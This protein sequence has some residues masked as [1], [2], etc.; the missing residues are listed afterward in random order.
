MC[1]SDVLELSQMITDSHISE[2]NHY[3]QDERYRKLTD[4][5]ALCNDLDNPHKFKDLVANNS[6]EKL[7]NVH[8]TFCYKYFDDEDIMYSKINLSDEKMKILTDTYKNVIA[9]KSD[10]LDSMMS[11]MIFSKTYFINDDKLDI[12]AFMYEMM[13]M[14]NC[15]FEQAKHS[16]PAIPVDLQEKMRQMINEFQTETTMN[17]LDHVYQKFTDLQLEIMIMINLAAQYLKLIHIWCDFHN[18][19]VFQLSSN[20]QR[21]YLRLLNNYIKLIFEIAFIEY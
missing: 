16:I 6:L 3:Y 17:P 8:N 13:S 7:L 12:Y 19:K 5:M 14:C 2:Y 21:I 1:T 9:R 15:Y 11:S 4:L 18:I 20:L 10:M